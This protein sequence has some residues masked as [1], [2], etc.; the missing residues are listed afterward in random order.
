MAGEGNVEQASRGEWVLLRERPFEQPRSTPIGN[1]IRT[2]TYSPARKQHGA[3]L[4]RR[5]DGDRYKVGSPSMRALFPCSY[6]ERLITG[7]A[8]GLC[9]G[10]DR[11]GS[12]QQIVWH[13]P[14]EDAGGSEGSEGDEGTR[15]CGNGAGG[16]V[17]LNVSGS[18]MVSTAKG[19]EGVE[20]MI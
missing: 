18:I 8:E 4:Y 3:R 2:G 20:V 16:V 11:C 13:S 12:T 1:N 9:Q 19:N 17:L 15:T 6:W 5:A 14:A 10:R 7:I